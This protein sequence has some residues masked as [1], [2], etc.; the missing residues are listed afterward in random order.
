MRTLTNDEMMDI[1][2][3]VLKCT[4]GTGGVN[5]TGSLSDWAAAYDALVGATADAMCA[6]SGNC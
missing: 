5:C 3:G 1:S 6:A 4:A 2:G